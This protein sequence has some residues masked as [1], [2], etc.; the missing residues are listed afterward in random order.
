MAGRPQAAPPGPTSGGCGSRSGTSWR[1]PTPRANTVRDPSHP[2]P[3][4]HTHIH[5]RTLQCF[6]C[7]PRAPV[8]SRCPQT[9]PPGPWPTDP[10][11]PRGR[12]CELD[13]PNSNE[14]VVHRPE[15]SQSLH[16]LGTPVRPDKLQRGRASGVCISNP[17][18][19]PIDLQHAGAGGRSVRKDPADTGWMRRQASPQVPTLPKARRLGT[20]RPPLHLRR[21]PAIGDE[22]DSAFFHPQRWLQLGPRGP[23]ATSA[24]TNPHRFAR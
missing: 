5:E 15:V 11:P 1:S 17:V 6:T 8:H 21:R 20:R 18:G 14:D 24:A 19:A 10:P 2:R 9:R 12:R 13:N 22:V 16:T 4:P 7:T 23:A 3:Q